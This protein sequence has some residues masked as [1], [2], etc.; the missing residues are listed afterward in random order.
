M[1]VSLVLATS[2]LLLVV[3]PIAAQCSFEEQ[4]GILWGYNRGGCFICHD[5][6]DNL[7]TDQALEEA[8]KQTCA[9]DLNCVAYEFSKSPLDALSVYR[10][11]GNCCLE[12]DTNDAATEYLVLPG[13]ANNCQK[14]T[15]C[16]TRLQ[17]D[18]TDACP[19]ETFSTQCRQIYEYS[20]QVGADHVTLIE[21]GCGIDDIVYQ[22]LLDSASQQCMEQAL[23]PDGQDSEE[24]DCQFSEPVVGEAN[25]G[26]NLGGCFACEN[27]SG[28]AM[29]Y[30]NELMAA[31]DQM[32]RADPNCISFEVALAPVDPYYVYIQF[33]VNCCIEYNP[34]DSNSPYFVTGGTSNNC[35]KEMN[36]WDRVDKLSSCPA[37][38]PHPTCRQ[39]ESFSEERNTNL[40]E[41][42][43]N[44]CAFEDDVV[45]QTLLD[46]ASDMCT[47]ETISR[48][49]TP[50]NTGSSTSSD[51]QQ[52]TKTSAGKSWRDRVMFLNYASLWV[53]AQGLATFL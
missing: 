4:E 20:E 45:A 44:D 18:T 12:Y 16:W 51:Q 3:S 15:Y 31:C 53:V 40:L 37:S 41:Y 8:C 39:T 7:L 30:G 1:Q 25:F 47:E 26:L 2:I 21:Q 33:P 17:R 19:S 35:Q 27:E 24:S 32:C 6:S 9:A 52:S 23:P 49:S 50:Q 38:E 22:S 29:V 28:D 48:E 36:C 42:V 43:R 10:G 11:S 13:T 46:A 14:E 5:D 34:V